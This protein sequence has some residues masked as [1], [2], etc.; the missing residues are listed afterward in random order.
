MKKILSIGGTGAMGIYLT[1][2]LLKMGYAVDVISLDEKTSDNEN[3]RYIKANAMDDEFITEILKNGYDAIVDFMIYKSPRKTFAKRMKLF[4][5]NTKHYLYFSSYRIYANKEVPIKETSP[6]LLDTE[7]DP[8]FLSLIDTEYS[9]YKAVGEDM[10]KESGYTNWSI[11]R[12][13]ITYSSFRFQLVTLEA[14]VVVRRMREG[15]TVILPESAMDKQATMC[16]AGDVAKML[17]RIIL[18]EKA[19]AEAF[20]PSTSEHHTWR[21]IAE[22][23]GRIGGLKYAVVDDETY[24]SLISDENYRTYASNQLKYDRLF[25]RIVDNSKVLSVT[26]MTQDE[27]MPLEKGLALEL[28]ALPADFKWNSSIANDRMDE[29][30]KNNL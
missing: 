2:E 5:E 7:T 10:L 30:I 13:V 25:D 29:Y 4:L 22:I 9:L 24:I 8:E 21:E 26:G 19:Y 28:A 14:Q 12:P 18:N 3:L 15:K 1:P 11:I 20:T 16:W 6:R 23:Y 27:M 17:A